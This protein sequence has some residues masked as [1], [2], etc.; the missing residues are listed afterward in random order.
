LK[1]YLPFKAPAIMT[2]PKI[3]IFRHVTKLFAIV[4][5][6]TPKASATET[7]NAF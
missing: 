1:L 6:S 7:F 5:V 2:N 4:D 3:N